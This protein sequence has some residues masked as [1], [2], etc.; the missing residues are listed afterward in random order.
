MF[1]DGHLASQTRFLEDKTAHIEAHICYKSNGLIYGSNYLFF[2]HYFFICIL[3]AYKNIFF[4]NVL[5][6]ELRPI[7]KSPENFGGPKT[8]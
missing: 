7:K 2:S 5:V 1:L 4:P 3:R 6:H 8:I